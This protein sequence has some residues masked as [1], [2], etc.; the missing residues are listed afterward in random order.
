M[1][2]FIVLIAALSSAQFAWAD[3]VAGCEIFLRKSVE[4]DG[5]ATGAFLDTYA[6]A[7]DF[8]SSVYDDEDGFLME[9][10]GEKIKALFCTRHNVIPTLRDFPVLA[11]G[12]PFVVSN[13]FNVVDSSIL[14]I[15][16][17]ENKFKHVYKGPDLPEDEALAL[18]DVM[19][20]FNLQPHGL[21]ED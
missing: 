20:I 2:K 21:G 12:I 9:V 16:F 1:R 15:F 13:D 4:I 8:I 14:T 7:E 18:K 10:E 17:K 5:K 11:T 6:P 3:N 19:E